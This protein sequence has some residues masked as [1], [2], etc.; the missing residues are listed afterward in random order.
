[1]RTLT[2]VDRGERFYPMP[3]LGPLFPIAITRERPKVIT[4]PEVLAESCT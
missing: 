4:N 1:M 2:T 3:P